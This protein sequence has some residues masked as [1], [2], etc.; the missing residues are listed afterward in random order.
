MPDEDTEETLLQRIY[1]LLQLK[2][3]ENV[4][5]VLKDLSDDS[6]SISGIGNKSSENIY[7]L[8]KII[9]DLKVEN[10]ETESNTELLSD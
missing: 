1:N 2:V 9:K 10:Q 3:G 8:H 6:K 5:D 4:L 7:K